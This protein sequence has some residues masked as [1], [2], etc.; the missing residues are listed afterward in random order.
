MRIQIRSVDV[1]VKS[2]I[3]KAGKPYS[4]PEQKAYVVDDEMVLPFRVS[5]GR[6]QS[7]FAPGFYSL[8]ASSF[9]ITPWGSLELERV[10]LEPESPPVKLAANSGK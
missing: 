2:G 8:S 10:K 7:P 3:S 4:I 6:D 1:E 5:L 9:G